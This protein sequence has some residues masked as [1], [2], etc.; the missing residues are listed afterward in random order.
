MTGELHRIDGKLDIHA[1]LHFAA[2]AGVDELLGGLGDDGVA[3][4]IEPIDERA[5]RR[6]F[7]ILDN[8]RVIERPHQRPA[9]LEF[10]EQTPVIDV[11]TQVARGGIEVGSIDEQGGAFGRQQQHGDP[12]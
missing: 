8:G 7:L 6:V 2:A 4:V 9:A 10:L 11:E 1:A 12:L 3:V 5:D